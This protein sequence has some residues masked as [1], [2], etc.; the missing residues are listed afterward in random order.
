[1]EQGE[2]GVVFWQHGQQIGERRQY[3]EAGAPAVTVLRP[4]QRHLLHDIG[5]RYVGR[6]L[7]IHGLGDD[8]SEVVCEAVRK[9]LMPVRRGIAMTEAGRYPDVAITHLDCAARYIVRPE[10]EGAAAFQ[11][12]AGM[13][14]MTG[15]DAVLDSASL[16]REAH[17][18]ATIVEGKDPPAV[19]D[20]EDRTMATLHNAPA[21]RHQL[22]KASHEH[23]FAI[24][25]VHAHTS[26]IR[27]FPDVTGTSCPWEI[28]I[29]SCKR[30]KARAEP[31]WARF[32][33]NCPAR[34]QYQSANQ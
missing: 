29:L 11:I 33:A 14:P 13:V 19:V 3:C 25:C 10:V 23:E 5:R 26:S 32:G 31:E 27:P 34:V 4:K 17:V 2:I 16:K 15:Q 12:E 1:V 24:R 20:D 7:T 8:E 21:L 30:R 9:P 28:S 18:G 6:E 22:F